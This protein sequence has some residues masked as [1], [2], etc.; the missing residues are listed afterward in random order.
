MAEVIVRDISKSF[1][2]DKTAAHTAVLT[3]LSLTIPDGEFFFLLGPSGCGKTTLLRIIAGLAEPDAGTILIDGEDM[4]AVPAHKR[5]IAMV[6]QNYA[7]WPHMTVGENVAF[8]LEMSQTPKAELAERTRDA[9]AMTQISSLAMRFP[10]ELSGG[11]QQRVALARALA[12]RPRVLLLDE[13][14]SNLDVKLRVEMRQELRALHERTKITMIYVT[15]DQGEALALGSRI[16][17]LHQGA[18]EQVGIAEE[19][20]TK[21]STPFVA[22]FFGGVALARGTAKTSPTGS[23]IMITDGTFSIPTH[24]PPGE[25]TLALRPE[26]ILP[27]LVQG[28]RCKI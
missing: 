26:A 19:L 12:V 13:P 9:L 23:T 18:L 27:S 21:P 7:L 16:A 2:R 20:L 4:R 17:L 11:Q 24:L 15:H 22:E 1:A 3:S 14:L 28:N 8:G 25:V 10:H 5:G 6:F